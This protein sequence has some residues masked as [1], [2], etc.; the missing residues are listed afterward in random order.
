MK[1][2]SHKK[3]KKIQQAYSSYVSEGMQ[4]VY[5]HFIELGAKKGKFD[6]KLVIPHRTTISTNV[7]KKPE[8]GMFYKQSRKKKQKLKKKT[9][10]KHH[11][12]KPY[13]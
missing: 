11:K 9:Q 7:N 13:I 6:C 3:I 8:L 5:N 12:T 1:K 10:T 2:K 4:S